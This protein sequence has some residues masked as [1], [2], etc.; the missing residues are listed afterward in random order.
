MADAVVRADGEAPAGFLF[1]RA[2]ALSI[3]LGDH[4]AVDANK[5]PAD[6]VPL[7]PK[8]SGSAPIRAKITLN[9]PYERIGSQPKAGPYLQTAAK[10]LE[11]LERVFGFSKCAFKVLNNQADFDSAIRRF[12]P[13]RPSQPV[14]LHARLPKK[15]ENGPEIPA[16]YFRFGLRAPDS[17]NPRRKTLKVSGLVRECSRFSK[18]DGEDLV[19]HD[20]R[21]RLQ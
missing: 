6:F 3:E 19:R 1:K 17:L 5:T 2:S 8:R 21:R 20:C 16:L 10:L 11:L 14:R 18:T 7:A 12:D 9:E 15:R 13:S 4:D